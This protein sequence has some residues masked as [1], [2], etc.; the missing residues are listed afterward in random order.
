MKLEQLL[1]TTPESLAHEQH[2]AL[3]AHVIEKLETVLKAIKDENYKDIDKLISYSPAGD[4]MGGENHF[5]D[6]S[7][8]HKQPL[9]IAEVTERLVALKKISNR[10]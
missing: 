3:K 8:T 5:I 2:A 9:D 10:K 7:F 1:N 4:C 6:F